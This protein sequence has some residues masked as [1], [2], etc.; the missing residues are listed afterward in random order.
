L[1][2]QLEAATSY[3]RLTSILVRPKGISKTDSLFLSRLTSCS[4][5]CVETCAPVACVDV[6]INLKRTIAKR[7]SKYTN[8]KPNKMN[9][10]SIPTNIFPFTKDEFAA[11]IKRRE[12]L[13]N[14]YEA[15]A[16]E[17]SKRQQNKTATK[18]A[19]SSLHVG[20]GV[21]TVVCAI[22]LPAG[23][24][25]APITAAVA[26]TAALGLG[27]AGAA[28][29]IGSSAKLCFDDKSIKDRLTSL[30]KEVEDI[31]NIDR[32]LKDHID[33]VICKCKNLA[34]VETVEAPGAI[35]A[36]YSCPENV[37][38][39]QEGVGF[40]VSL[41]EG[42]TE[43]LDLLSSTF[44]E[45]IPAFGIAAAGTEFAATLSGVF[46][47]AFA[48][49]GVYTIYKGVQ[50]LENPFDETIQNMK[51]TATKIREETELIRKHEQYY[52][53]ICLQ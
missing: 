37:K 51:V 32:K 6:L 53:T 26:G 41:Q 4:H 14:E 48:A 1:T 42:N 21:S 43:C 5:N 24:I 25:S 17:L 16:N 13:A 33:D 3:N 29:N 31:A 11:H 46:G 12:A 18:I 23:A 28:T 10:Q 8:L 38:K 40:V 44:A 39:I 36:I 15:L 35:W 7:K 9:D 52:V 45:G 47:G 34:S 20:G 27:I 19:A 49:F 30:N 50:D 22:A 2:L